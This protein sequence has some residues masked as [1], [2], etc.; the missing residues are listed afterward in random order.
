MFQDEGRFC[1]ISQT[2][3]CWAPAG[4]STPHRQTVHSAVLLCLCGHKPARRA[5]L[6]S[7]VLP[8]VDAD[9]MS[10]FLAE[11]ARRHSDELILMLLD[12]AGWHRAYDLVVPDNI[13][14]VP[15]P[16]YSPELNPVEHLWDELSEKWFGNCV[17]DC[18]TGVEDRLV[19]ALV[20]LANDRQRLRAMTAFPWIVNISMNAT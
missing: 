8:S 5:L 11:V 15:L 17:F 3:R 2:Y 10:I 16:P 20:T 7:L 13:W 9:I 1:C 4:H 12:G 18:L 6:D 14:L 19:E